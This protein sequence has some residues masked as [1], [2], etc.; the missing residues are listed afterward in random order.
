MTT[1]RRVVARY[2]TGR[3]LD[4]RT[5]YPYLKRGPGRWPG[6]KRQVFRIA[7]PAVGVGVLAEPRTMAEVAG[8]ALIVGGRTLRR[9]WR[10]RRFRREYISPT[11]AAVRVPLG[12]VRVRLHVDPGLGSLTPRLAKPQSPAEKALRRWYGHAERYLR[13]PVDQAM[14]GWWW[15]EGYVRPP[16]QRFAAHF[17]RP[18]ASPEPRIEL[19]ADTPY[20]TAEQR[21]LI[22]A[23]IKSKI[24]VSDLIERWDQVG[25]QVGAT[26]TVRK[27]PPAMVGVDEL[28]AAQAGLA[29]WE[30]FIGLGPGRLPVTVS[31][32]DDS[33]HIAVSAGSGAGK[34]VLAMLIAVQILAR[35][36]RVTILDRK[37][38][39]RW[40]I[41][42]PGVDYCTRPEEMHAAL[43]RLAAVAD[44]RNAE[45]MHQPE[46]WVPGPRE[47]IICEELNAT[48]G[49]LTNHWADVRAKSDPKKSPAVSALADILFMGRSALV[50]VLAI[51]QMLTAR[52]IG[53]PE[54]RENFALRFLARYTSNAWKMLV[55]EAAMPRPSRTLGRWQL[56]VGGVATEV[57]VCYLTAA[58]ARRIAAPVPGDARGPDS[59]PSGDV[60]GD[61]GQDGLLSLR[62]ACDRGVLPWPHANAKKRLQRARARADESA[63]APAGRRGAQTDLYRQRDLEAWVV[64]ESVS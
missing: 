25:A 36:G 8:A 21:N 49:Q 3:P 55:P 42:L 35:G 57:Q 26:W 5:G 32:R 48:I 10:Q 13:L 61:R 14:I 24:P 1:T 33:A 2:L 16:A 4:G 64:S 56:V 27:R 45:A 39:H 12:D 58:Q 44:R 7:G 53:G 51:A 22:S 59:A 18:G 63:P 20:L 30:F 62:E 29:E 11:L 60:P 15:A 31:L 54:A 40:A 19:T 41:G 28:L 9:R 6:W 23:I 37:G 43:I 34:S 46:D 52:A 38:S 47:L 17:R 50:T